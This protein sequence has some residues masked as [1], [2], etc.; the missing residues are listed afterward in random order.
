MRQC[1]GAFLHW[2]IPALVHSCIPPASSDAHQDVGDEDEQEDEETELLRTSQH[3]L[4][5][6]MQECTNARMRFVH[7]CI[8][9]F[10]HFVFAIEEFR[11]RKTSP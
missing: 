9:A 3:G 6:E 1:I 8:R 10:L 7:W 11:C 2:C 5:A 4:N